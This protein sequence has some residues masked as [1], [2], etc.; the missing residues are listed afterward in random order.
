MKKYFYFRD[1]WYEQSLN[2]DWLEEHASWVVYGVSDW[3]P[4]ISL[5]D[6]AVIYY[7]NSNWCVTRER[8]SKD[9]IVLYEIDEFVYD[10]LYRKLI[11]IENN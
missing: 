4:N 8:R 3:I 6:Y 2:S 7:S 5:K 1:I 9:D 11:E 10:K